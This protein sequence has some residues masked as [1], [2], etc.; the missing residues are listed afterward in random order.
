[1]TEP[2]THTIDVP[3]VTLTYDIRPAGGTTEPALLM[4]GSPMDAGGFAELAGYFTER[5]VVTYDPRGT[6]RSVRTDDARESTP[7]Q[8]ADD[9]HRVIAAVGGPVDIF[10]SS[11]GAVNALALVTAHPGDVRTLVAHEPPAFGVLPDGENAL[12]AIRAISEAYEK[13]GFGAGMSRFLAVSMHRGEVPA[14]LADQ[15]GPDPAMFGLPTDDD[16]SR[17]DAL[18]HQNIVTCTHFQP[19]FDALRAAPTRIVLGA[20]EESDGELANRSAKAIAERLGQDV[21]IFPSHHGG[22]VGG[23]GGWAGKPAEF[24]VTLREALA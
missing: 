14:G 17:D 7:Q 22:F 23:D 18:L 19:D 24:A 4:I 5:T 16:G 1:M 13:D 10:A 6:A 12:A 2:Q 15:P 3:G 20:G 11:G 9:L 8:H 21:V